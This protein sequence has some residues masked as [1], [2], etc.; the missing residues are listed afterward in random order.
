MAVSEGVSDQ[1]L[2]IAGPQVIGIIEPIAVEFGL[3]PVVH[4]TIRGALGAIGL[5]GEG[6][7]AAVID[8]VSRSRNPGDTRLS[9]LIDALWRARSELIPT[10]LFANEHALTHFRSRYGFGVGTST[11]RWA[12][13]L[14][15]PEAEVVRNWLAKAV[16]SREEQ[17]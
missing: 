1:L 15:P 11:E 9:S 2:V 17:A 7:T 14:W 13:M 3:Q 6:V 5:N 8:T 16:A 12:A 10:A 4:D